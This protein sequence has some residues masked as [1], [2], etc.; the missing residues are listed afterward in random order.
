MSDADC[1]E[2]LD[3]A[4]SFFGMPQESWLD[5]RLGRSSAKWNVIAQ[6]TFMA[7]VDRVPGPGSSF[8]TDGWDGYPRARERLLASLSGQRV[9]NPLVL[10]GDVH[11]SAVTD[12]KVNFDDAKSPVVATEFVCPSITSQGPAQKRVEIFMLE[13]RHVKF[14]NG[15]LRGYSTVELT[16]QRCV[17]QIRVV[18]SVKQRTSPIRSVAT[19]AV[20][21]GRPGAERV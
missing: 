3:P 15:V 9:S 5:E 18:D 14:A 4:L 21:S 11:M 6:Q 19:Y 16:P 17:T 2:R 12:L 20:E 8:W 13:N 7:Q 1:P 10:S